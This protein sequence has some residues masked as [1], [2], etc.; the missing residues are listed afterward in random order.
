MRFR[1]LSLSCVSNLA[2]TWCEAGRSRAVRGWGDR[3]IIFSDTL[4]RS[5]SYASVARQ[6][7][8]ERAPDT[9]GEVACMRLFGRVRVCDLGLLL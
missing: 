3:G 7:T 6:Y 8:S 1:M 2:T 5:M 9:A 4:T